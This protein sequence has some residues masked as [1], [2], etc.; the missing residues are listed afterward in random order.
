MSLFFFTG[1]VRRGIQVN[2]ALY[3]SMGQVSLAVQTCQICRKSHLLFGKKKN[4]ETTSN[5]QELL[6]CL[7]H[8]YD[9]WVQKLISLGYKI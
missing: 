9:K 1:E 8:V 6:Y 3:P 5:L 7:A 2:Q 4:G